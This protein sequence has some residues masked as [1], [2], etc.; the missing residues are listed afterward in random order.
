M[1]R[2]IFINTCF[3]YFK[4]KKIISQ[5]WEEIEIYYS[6][7][8]R[9]YHNLTHLENLIQQ[10]EPFKKNLEDLDTVYFSIFYH[11][12]IYNPHKQNNEE[13][14][15]K[16]AVTRL[17]SISVPAAKISRSK[18]QI[19]ATKHVNNHDEDQDSKFFTDAD[20]SIL[21]TDTEI[22]M[23]YSQ[24]IRKEYTLYP[25]FMYNPGRK[26][27]LLHFLELERIFK[28]KQFYDLYEVKAR[29]NIEE[30]LKLL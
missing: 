12:I 6:H 9:Y 1:L 8:K 13:R 20:L 10:L 25:D 27:V 3:R 21:G 2:D 29:K 24:K 7:K 22:Y 26:K 19:L 11:D 14:S 15:A 28:T 5:L 17:K 30:E 16:V 4:N 18:K 23:D